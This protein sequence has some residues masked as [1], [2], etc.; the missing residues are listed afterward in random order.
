MFFEIEI[1]QDA[2]D[3][4]GGTFPV[5][6]GLGVAERNIVIKIRVLSFQTIKVFDIEK[7][8]YGPIRRNQKVILRSEFLVSSK[9]SR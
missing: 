1:V 7:L 8:A 9:S 5:V 2:V 6:F 3:E 4:S